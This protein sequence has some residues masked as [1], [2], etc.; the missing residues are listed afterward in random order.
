MGKRE[1]R[2]ITRR[3][4]EQSAEGIAQSAGPQVVAIGRISGGISETYI[5]FRA[6]PSVDDI[7]SSAV[8]KVVRG[9]QAKAI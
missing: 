7:C 1:D 4:K 3:V 9:L 8:R 6:M 5:T 2:K